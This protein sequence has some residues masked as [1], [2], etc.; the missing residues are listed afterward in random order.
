MASIHAADQV[1]YH[2]VKEDMRHAQQCAGSE[3]SSLPLHACFTS[4]NLRNYEGWE[5]EYIGSK[6]QNR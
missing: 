5:I 2:V 4:S 6:G 1:Q 3:V